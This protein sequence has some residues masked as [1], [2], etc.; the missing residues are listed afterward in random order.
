VVVAIAG[1]TQPIHIQKQRAFKQ[2]KRYI[3]ILTWWTVID[4]T[5][6]RDQYEIIIDF[7]FIINL[8]EKSKRLVHNNHNQLHRFLDLTNLDLHTA[9]TQLQS[10][11]LVMV[12][13][14][15]HIPNRVVLDN[16]IDMMNTIY[17]GESMSN[18]DYM[19]MV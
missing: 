6:L 15:I 17:Y 3:Y 13:D 1:H 8:L 5:T 18:P 2:I 16:Y 4:W 12:E 7:L 9:P 11:Q 19:V 14:K 10:L